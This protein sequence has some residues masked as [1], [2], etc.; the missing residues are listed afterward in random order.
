[1]RVLYFST[2]YGPHDH[3][4]LSALAQTEHEV[5]FLQLVTG[6]RVTEHRPIPP[7]IHRVSWDGAGRGFRWQDV[8]RLVAALRRIIQEVQPE[9][10]HAGPIQTCAFLAILAGFRPV[11]TMSWGFDLM[12]DAY[13]N[14]W[15]RWVTRYTLRRSSFFVSDAQVTR[16]RAV[17]FGM[18]RDRTEVFPWGV[19][20]E[21]FRPG[22][23]NRTSPARLR[24]SAGSGRAARPAARKRFL[25]LCNRSWEP[26]YGVD[27]LV[28]AFVLAA[29]QNDALSLILLSGG[30]DG[31]TIRRI[32]QEGGQLDRVQF[33][34]HVAQQDQPRW[35]QRADLFISPSHVDGSSVS[36]MEALACGSAV[37]I[38]DIPA[39]KEWVRHDVNGWLFRDGDPADLAQKILWISSQPRV[40]QRVRREARKVAVARADWK[41]NFKVLLRAYKRT[42]AVR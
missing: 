14:A 28:R 22:P 3:R 37:L 36:L 26:R 31:N 1:M 4:F 35:Y 6:G 34:G 18:Q 19:D 8:P 13:R 24:S 20:L 29:R 11:L 16:N 38:S 23:R 12:Q 5:H 15:W 33:A 42:L 39:N 32:L 25:I 9:I 17:A 30:S 21:K 10:I 41:K 7:S 40:I 2:G 27:V